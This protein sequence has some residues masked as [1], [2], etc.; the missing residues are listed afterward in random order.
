[1][2]TG[3]GILIFIAL[4]LLGAF[5]GGVVAYIV[6]T[7]QLCGK[8]VLSYTVVEDGSAR[9]GLQSRG[10][11]YGSMEEEQADEFQDEPLDQHE[12]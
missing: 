7:G 11:A 8:R 9:M 2:A 12:T 4:V 1:M 6:L 3:K 10:E 5:L